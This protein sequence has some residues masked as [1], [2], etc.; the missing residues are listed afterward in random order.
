MDASVRLVGVVL[1]LL[2]L[3]L[4]LACKPEEFPGARKRLRGESTPAGGSSLESSA[5]SETE[6]DPVAPAIEPGA[7]ATSA[8]PEGAAATS[9]AVAATAAPRSPAVRGLWVLAEGSVRVLDDPA[10]VAPLLDRAGRL[11]VTDLFVQV[12]RGGRAFYP[13]DPAFERAP[14]VGRFAVDPLALLIQ[15]AHARGMRVH[16]WVNV[17][18]LSTRR[19]A[20]LLADLGREV[21]L[22][23]RRGRSLL[24]YPEFDLPQPDRQFY[25]MGTPGLY[26]DPAVPSVRQRILATFG[27]LVERYPDLDGLHLDY[28][29]H[30]DL[31]PFIPGSRFGV[32]LDFGYGAIARARYRAETGRADP[33]EGA[34]PGV[35]RDAEAWDEWKRAQ[36]TTLVEEI[37]ATTQ[38]IH[39]GLTLSAAVI[40]HVER[41]YLT[42]AQDWPGWLASGALDRVIPMVY[43]RDEPLLRYQLE[44]YVGLTGSDRIW[45]GLGVWLFEAEPARAVAQLERLRSLP[46]SGEVLFSDDAIAQ[47]PGLLEALAAPAVVSP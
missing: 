19:D 37:R 21:I 8:E 44:G 23:D 6:G 18:S 34:A 30:P 32:G 47:S 27:D 38:A 26:L 16:A 22:V 3:A 35:V 11:G 10:R 45:P 7:D 33:I 24:D 2:G 36:V 42:L 20:K 17:L 40:S 1:V 9:T 43:T 46:F 31:L 28:I 25:R 41:A 13:A 14:E 12:Y 29:R 15:D 4:G 39:P 5:P